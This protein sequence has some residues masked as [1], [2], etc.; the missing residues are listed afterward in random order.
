MGSLMG[1]RTASLLAASGMAAGMVFVA[2]CLVGFLSSHTGGP[3]ASA[4]LRAAR[5]VHVVS[6]GHRHPI[7]PTAPTAFF[8]EETDETTDG[9]PAKAELLTALL[10]GSF[11]GAIA[12]GLKPVSPALPGPRLSRPASFSFYSVV[13]S[14]QRRS[15]S[16]LLGNFRL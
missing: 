5:P 11:F 3:D 4:F 14:F 1:R 13:R 6:D 10:S 7:G 2:V 8:A 16:T 15:P 9:L 12:W